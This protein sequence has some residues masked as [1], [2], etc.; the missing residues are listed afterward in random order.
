MTAAL[1]AL[2]DQV[3]LLTNSL[4]DLLQACQ[5]DAGKMDA[6]NAQYN[7]SQANY[8]KC[9]NQIFND[10]DPGVQALVAQMKQEQTTLAAQVRHIGDVA[11]VI[12][13]VTAAVQTGAA[14]AAKV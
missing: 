1:Q 13:A 3:D 12:N 4:P 11:A 6:V 7:A 9:I 5:N 8:Y 14:L 10:D 2:Q